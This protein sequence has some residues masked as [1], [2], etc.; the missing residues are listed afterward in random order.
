[1]GFASDTAVRALGDGRFAGEI[2]DRRWW[3]VN[4]PNGGFVAAMLV[5]A[6]TAALGDPSRP[7]R[8]LSVHYPAAPQAGRLAIEVRNERV[9]RTA[10][11]LSAR[12]TQDGETVALALAAFSSAFPG[13]AFQ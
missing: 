2:R 4:G 8:S 13:A 1:M 9:G 7:I 6:L 5:N 12:A 11:Y 10:A 3:V